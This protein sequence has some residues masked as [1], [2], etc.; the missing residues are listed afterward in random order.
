[1][2]YIWYYL[3]MFNGSQEETHL[4]TVRVSQSCQHDDEEPQTRVRS[5]SIP[6]SLPPP[7]EIFDHSLFS[8]CYCK[9]KKTEKN[10][11]E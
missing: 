1:M 4:I 7:P 10:E 3:S 6:P 2:V 11:N 9:Y 8:K 5:I